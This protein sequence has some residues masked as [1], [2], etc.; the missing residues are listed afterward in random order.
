[1]SAC[2]LGQNQNEQFQLDTAIYFVVLEGDTLFGH[3]SDMNIE[4]GKFSQM[5]KLNYKRWDS[6]YIVSANK[7]G[8]YV[9][10]EQLNYLVDG[11]FTDGQKSG[12]WEYFFD[13]GTS[14]CWEQILLSDYTVHY[15][16]DTVIWED[17]NFAWRK[18]V[19]YVADSTSIFGQVANYN[20]ELIKFNCDT[21]SGC[22]FWLT[23]PKITIAQTSI[24]EF[25][26]TLDGIELGLYDR[27]IRMHVEKK[28]Y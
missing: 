19:Y 17:G 28:K 23:N 10:V 22:E 9:F 25:E 16:R 3:Y 4:N 6:D 5:R 20:D 7:T 18:Q 2:A 8:A 1:M 26:H 12:K 27:Q 14:Y 13:M 21:S 11:E 15:K 24:N